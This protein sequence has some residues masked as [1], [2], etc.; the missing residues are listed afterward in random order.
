MTLRDAAQALVV[1]LEEIAA[2]KQYESVWVL[3]HVHGGRYT[4]PN[5]TAELAALKEV[6]EEP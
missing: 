1:R 6:L 3:Y 5:Y 4:G 2:D